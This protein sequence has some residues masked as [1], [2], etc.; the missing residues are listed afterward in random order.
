MFLDVTEGCFF[1]SQPKDN[2]SRNPT[3]QKVLFA[4]VSVPLIQNLTIFKE[5]S[6][7]QFEKSSNVLF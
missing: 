1:G 5:L 4:G 7:E 6:K 3:Q 2:T